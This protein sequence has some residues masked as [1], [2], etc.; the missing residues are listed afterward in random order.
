MHCPDLKSGRFQL[1]LVVYV[2]LD[3]LGFLA[4]QT[5]VSR[6]PAQ[7]YGCRCGRYSHTGF[8][9]VERRKCWGIHHPLAFAQVT[10]PIVVV[11]YVVLSVIHVFGFEICCDPAHSSWYR[12]SRYWHGGPSC[13][14]SS[15]GI[16]GTIVI[17]L[18]VKF[19][20]QLVVAVC[21]FLDVV[22]AFAATGL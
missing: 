5:W 3:V 1:G 11:V 4:L 10:N 20:A 13:V 22:P 14:E 12:H 6:D 9:S 7:F 18:Q 8:D 17:L 2:V 16:G 15:A 19:S 21:V